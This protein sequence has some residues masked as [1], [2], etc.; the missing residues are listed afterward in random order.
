MTLHVIIISA[1]P[2]TM[3]VTVLPLSAHLEADS[4]AITWLLLNLICF[5]CLSCL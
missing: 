3:H 2:S 5:L 4:Y 1:M